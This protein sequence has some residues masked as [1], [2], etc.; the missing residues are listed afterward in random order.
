MVVHI[1]YNQ[2]L[3]MNFVLRVRKS[4]EA[5]V[6]TGDWNIDLLRNSPKT[7]QLKNL[8]ESFDLRQHVNEPTYIRN[9]VGGLLD[10]LVSLNQEV[11]TNLSIE[12]VDGISENDHLAI[13]FGLN[14]NKPINNSKYVT[15]RD[16]KRFNQ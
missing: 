16:F 14:Y 7:T 8:F 11:I 6:I 5:L 1:S 10:L 4:V 12:V 15:Y 3:S 9:N 2:A 13:T